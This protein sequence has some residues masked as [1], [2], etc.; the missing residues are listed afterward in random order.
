MSHFF[1]S[2]ANRLF[3]IKHHVGLCITF[4]LVLCACDSGDSYTGSGNPGSG[5][6]QPPRFS[7][8]WSAGWPDLYHDGNPYNSDNFVVYSEASSEE[9]RKQVAE[10][11]EVA[12]ADVMSI[13]D[14][15]FDDLDFLTGNPSKK[16]HILADYAQ[17]NQWGL[18]YRDGTIM[19][20]LDSPNFDGD[21]VRW[22]GVL[23]HEITLWWSFYSLVTHDSSRPI[24][25][26]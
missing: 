14:I 3:P 16:I 2:R 7:G 4:L 9:A 25:C 22:K 6:S 21:L 17:S 8:S 5:G 12:F 19:R 10:Y 23:Q 24:P 18:A 26:G 15:T 11:A 1:S 20:A 13:L